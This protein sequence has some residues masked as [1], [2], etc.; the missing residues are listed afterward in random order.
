V[1]AVLAL[2]LATAQSPEQCLVLKGDAAATATHAGKTYRFTS[3]ACRDEFLTDPERFAQLYDALLEMHAQ[4]L[5]VRKP[6][7]SLVPS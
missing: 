6:V 4:G 3:E 5:E 1:I 7:E 2:L